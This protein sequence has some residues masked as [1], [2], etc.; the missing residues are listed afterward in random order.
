MGTSV[1]RTIWLALLQSRLR[2]S[3]FLRQK[4]VGGESYCSYLRCSD[5]DMHGLTT[6]VW[7]RWYLHLQSASRVMAGGAGQIACLWHEEHCTS[8]RRLHRRLAGSATCISSATFFRR[9]HLRHPCCIWHCQ[10]CFVGSPQ[11]RFVEGPAALSSPWRSSAILRLS[12]SRSRMVCR[13]AAGSG[14]SSTRTNP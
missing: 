8:S 10:C 13:A 7:L 1:L 5:S 12:G 9:Q 4:R 14:W 11:Q 3:K 6:R 2:F